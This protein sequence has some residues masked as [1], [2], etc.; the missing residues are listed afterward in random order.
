MK[1]K[2]EVLKRF[3]EKGYCSGISCNECSYNGNSCLKYHKELNMRLAKIGAMAILR[4]F[5][6]KKKTLLSVGTKIKF[7]NG[8][9]ATVFRDEVNTRYVLDFVTR[10]E[11]M[12]YLIGKT[13]EVVE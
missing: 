9:I 1:T 8:E 2:R 5:P 3:T 12:E 7:D 4:M 10:F 11:L 13:W 6:E